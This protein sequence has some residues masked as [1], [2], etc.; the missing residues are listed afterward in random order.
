M[1]IQVPLNDRAERYTA[2]GGQTTFDVGFPVL[3]A[4]D[5]EVKRLRGI[6]V[7][8]LAY[9]ADYTISNIGAQSGAQ[10]LLTAGATAGDIIAI[11]GKR[12][13]ERVSNFGV[14]PFKPD[15]INL[16]LN[17]IML[18]VQELR[19]DLDRALRIDSLDAAS[20]ARLPLAADRA[21]K[22]LTFDAAGLPIASVSQAVG[23]AGPAGPQG[24]PGQDGQDGN[25]TGDVTAPVAFGA[26]T[27]IIRASNASKQ[28]KDSLATLDD[29]GGIVL[30]ASFVAK[31]RISPAQIVANTNDYA[32]AGFADASVLRLNSD[33]ARNLTGLAGGA[34]GRLIALVNTGSFTITLVNE[35]A[36]STAANR[37]AFGADFN[38]LAGM[39]L[40]LWYDSTSSRWRRLGG[41]SRGVE[42]E[43]ADANIVR[44]NVSSNLTKGYTATSY[45]IGTITSGTVTPDP[46][47]GNIQHYTANGAHTLAAPV[48]AGSYTLVLQV[49]NGASAGA[50]T[51]S[52]FEK[53]TG[54]SYATTSGNDY[55]FFVY[56]I[57]GFD[58]LHIQALQ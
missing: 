12:P 9:P 57:N 42:V 15:D 34:D 35:S 48:A 14:G 55:L 31:G 26:V 17:S 56:R 10:V 24:L 7:A 16:D 1:T 50:I 41:L 5:L 4:A 49:T 32:P 28:V 58:Y 29:T 13:A 20:V 6:I 43:A 22:T 44:G 3:A 38:L 51:F 40:W 18:A 46:A 30:P 52:G 39:G 27:R 36:S 19:R 11:D 47:N 54:D 45:S 21:L 23:P 8:T 25:G 37:F 33:A 2:S 53:Q